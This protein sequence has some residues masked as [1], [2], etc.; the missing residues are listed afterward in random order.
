MTP[1]PEDDITQA[2]T[3]GDT[4]AIAQISDKL[5]TL[6]ICIHLAPPRSFTPRFGELGS[7]LDLLLVKTQDVQILPKRKTI[8]P[9]KGSGWVDT[10]TIVHQ[11]VK[12]KCP[13]THQDP[14]SAGKVSGTS[15]RPDAKKPKK[16]SV[17]PN[18]R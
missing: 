18:T 17:R 13:R 3:T 5:Q 11:S 2:P 15:A 10:K 16:E 4:A 7:L 1:A 6:A 8:P 14:Y 9:N 12:S